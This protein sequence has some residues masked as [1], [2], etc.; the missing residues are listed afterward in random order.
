MDEFIVIV[1][2]RADAEIAT[3]LAQRVLLEKVDWLE[4]E[5][6]QH[7]FKWA[8][9]DP[10]TNYSCWKDLNN[11][12]E[13]V[14]HDGLRIRYL[15]HSK[16]GPQK[17]DYATTSKSLKLIH[18]LQ[19]KYKRPIK[20][21]I[22]IRDLDNQPE[23]RQSIE[24][25][26]SEYRDPQSPLAI[27]IGT[28]DRMREAWVLNGFI[29]S[30]ESEQEK[31]VLQEI[32]SQLKFDPC[33]ESHRL[34]STSKEEPERMRNPKVVLEIL[35]RADQLREQ[36]CWQETRLEILR[37]RGTKTGLALYLDEVEQRLMPIIA[38]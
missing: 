22:F 23:R 16:D 5:S 29:P 21:V 20:A 4:P 31:Q 8:G 13:R 27:V 36:Q 32:Q 24:Q 15:G 12:V 17:T 1:E 33:E 11:I 10:G 2:S 25:A 6:L 38:T 26:C 7:F 14:K 9:L 30:S 18:F 28:P 3:E 19:H 35:T 34:R 37:Q